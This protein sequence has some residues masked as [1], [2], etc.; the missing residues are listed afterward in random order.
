MG[1]LGCV[2]MVQIAILVAATVRGRLT[3]RV[4]EEAAEVGGEAV[5]TELVR[6]LLHHG[7][8]RPLLTLVVLVIKVVLQ[9]VRI[10]QYLLA[11]WV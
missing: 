6:N 2:S 11:L 9:D 10:R 5:L 4:L 1:G 7:L 3:L 8:G